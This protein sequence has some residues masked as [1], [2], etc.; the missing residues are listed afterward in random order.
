MRS[1]GHPVLAVSQPDAA[2]DLEQPITCTFQVTKGLA[3]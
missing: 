3:R 1:A 2:I